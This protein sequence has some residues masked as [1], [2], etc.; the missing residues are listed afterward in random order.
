MNRHTSPNCLTRFFLFWQESKFKVSFSVYKLVIYSQL[1]RF[2]YAGARTS[3]LSESVEKRNWSPEVH[4]FSAGQRNRYNGFSWGLRILS[5]YRY[6]SVCACLTGNK[7]CDRQ[8]EKQMQFSTRKLDNSISFSERMNA[9]RCLIGFNDGWTLS[10]NLRRQCSYLRQI[11][12]ISRR[13]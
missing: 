13:C 5:K 4:L 11:F 8:P 6:F 3:Q 10:K 9:P 1:R 2:Q 7:Q 12:L